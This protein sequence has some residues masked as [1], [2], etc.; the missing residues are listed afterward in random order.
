MKQ[1]R[2]R[3]TCDAYKRGHGGE[4]LQPR[5]IS[6]SS[7]PLRWFRVVIITNN[8]PYILTYAHVKLNQQQFIV[9]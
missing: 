2:L 5:H 9:M 7:R 6:S 3:T 8:K 1:K 4:R